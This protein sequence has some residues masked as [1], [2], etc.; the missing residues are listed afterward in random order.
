MIPGR[1]NG[2]AANPPIKTRR[3]ILDINSV[4]QP[5]LN[6]RPLASRRLAL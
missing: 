1:A 2:A 4:S 3:D 6:P 5:L